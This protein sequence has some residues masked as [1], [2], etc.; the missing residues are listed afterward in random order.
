VTSCRPTLAVSAILLVLSALGGAAS[1]PTAVGTSAATAQS[2]LQRDRQLRD[3]ACTAVAL[4]RLAEPGAM[5]DP[6]TLTRY[7]DF[8]QPDVQGLIVLQNDNVAAVYP[9]VKALVRIGSKAMPALVEVLK[10][11]DQ[12]YAVRRNAGR[13]IKLLNE[14]D[15]VLVIEHLLLAARAENGTARKLLEEAAMWISEW[16]ADRDRT[17]CDETYALYLRPVVGDH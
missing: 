16:C 17:A 11:P 12:K 3:P 8:V 4:A 14:H 9:A 10:R 13:T 5:G 7:L 15:S 6:T 1:C 2:Y